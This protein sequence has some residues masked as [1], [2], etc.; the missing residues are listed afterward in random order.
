MGQTLP[1]MSYRMRAAVAATVA[2][3]LLALML[4]GSVAAT[5]HGWS[6]AV[7]L[8]VPGDHAAARD[9]ASRKQARMAETRSTTST[10]VLPERRPPNA[11]PHGGDADRRFA[12]G[13]GVVGVIVVAVGGLLFRTL[14]NR[15][16]DERPQT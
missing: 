1:L 15:E 11:A 4:F 7:A 10:A 9:A 2:A 13:A 5:A 3:A 14:A 6:V 16:A 12:I 8:E